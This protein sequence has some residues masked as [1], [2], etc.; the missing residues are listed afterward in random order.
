MTILDPALQSTTEQPEGKPKKASPT[1]RRW[2]PGN[3]E[4]AI[5]LFAAII[6]GVLFGGEPDLTD[7][8]TQLVRGGPAE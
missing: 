2:T 5:L 7:A 8:L 4:L 3:S 6:A 1:C